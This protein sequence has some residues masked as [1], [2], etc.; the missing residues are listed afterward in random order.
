S[1]QYESSTIPRQ[2]LGR[3]AEGAKSLARR[4]KAS[5]DRVRVVKMSEVTAEMI[6]RGRGLDP[7]VSAGRRSRAAK[8]QKAR[9]RLTTSDTGDRDCDLAL[10]RAY[11]GA[12]THSAIAG[13][14]LIACS[15][16]LSFYWVKPDAAV[17]WAALS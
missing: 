15:A 12:R 9:E 13:L 10:L 6:E 4:S 14:A 7:K 17:V 1:V 2:S 3:L 5:V 11:S 16:I 8:V